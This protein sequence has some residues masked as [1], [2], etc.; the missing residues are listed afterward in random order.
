MT[1]ES[2]MAW[3]LGVLMLLAWSVGGIALGLGLAVLM[4]LGGAHLG[5]SAATFALSSTIGVALGM[6]ARRLVTR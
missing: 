4:A 3:A 5:A 2:R 6:G 1:S